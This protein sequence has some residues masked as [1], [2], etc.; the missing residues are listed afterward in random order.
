MKLRNKLFFLIIILLIFN[1]CKS[2][3]TVSDIQETVKIDT[4]YKTKV[5]K[6]V[7]RFT[8]TLRIEN[9]CD[10]LGS[11]KPFKQ[12][13]KIKQGNISLIGLN[14]TITADIDLNG[15]K[16]TL[17]K[18][19]KSKYEKKVSEY[20]EKNVVYKT[21]LYHWLIHLLLTIIIILLLRYK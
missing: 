16:N 8:D 12:L 20:K 17:E 13:I 11:L 15:Y 1:S 19:Y 9:A 2:A 18:V 10:S 21:P 6:E 7:E 4:I 3:K 14:N 5:V